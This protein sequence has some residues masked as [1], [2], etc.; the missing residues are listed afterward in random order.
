MPTKPLPPFPFLLLATQKNTPWVTK[1]GVHSKLHLLKLSEIFPDLSLRNRKI[2]CS[3]SSFSSQTK[4]AS[5]IKHKIPKENR[6]SIK[7][8]SQ[9]SHV[10]ILLE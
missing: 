3:A 4:Y 7:R 1:K 2:K 6:Y 5:P 8:P 9:H 10:N